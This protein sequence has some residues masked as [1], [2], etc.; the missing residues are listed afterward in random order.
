MWPGIPVPVSVFSAGLESPGIRAECPALPLSPAS[1]QVQC[2]RERQQ[3]PALDMGTPR[4]KGRREGGMVILQTSGWGLGTQLSSRVEGIPF[5]PGPTGAKLG[6]REL[7]S[8]PHSLI[9][10]GR[11]AGCVSNIPRGRQWEQKEGTHLKHLKIRDIVHI[12][13][14]IRQDF[15]TWEQKPVSKWKNNPVSRFLC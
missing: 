13:L 10:M 7:I 11:V 1:F 3:H 15:P 8:F 6:W 9:P 14:K 4:K 12:A 5:Y 2:L